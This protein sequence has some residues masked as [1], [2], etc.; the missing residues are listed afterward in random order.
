[1]FSEEK[2]SKENM[3]I[4]NS[5]ILCFIL[6]LLRNEM[7]LI[8]FDLNLLRRFYLIEE[9]SFRRYNHFCS[10]W[11]TALSIISL[12]SKDFTF[13]SPSLTLPDFSFSISILCVSNTTIQIFQVFHDLSASLSISRFRTVMLHLHISAY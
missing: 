2:V 12:S 6:D 9:T 5:H 3:W 4:V 13:H 10:I 7:I 1:M 8:C 11:L